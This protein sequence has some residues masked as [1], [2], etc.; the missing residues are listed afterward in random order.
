MYLEL[1]MDDGIGFLLISVIRDQFAVWV[2]SSVSLSEK[3]WYSEG[4]HNKSSEQFP[5]FPETAE[6]PPG[7]SVTHEIVCKLSR[8]N[9]TPK[10]DKNLTSD[11]ANVGKSTQ[12]SLP[13]IV[14]SPGNFL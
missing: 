3:S 13:I 14:K 11:H 7:H 12:S 2:L 6:Q 10:G 9:E 1:R 5:K 4:E 8:V